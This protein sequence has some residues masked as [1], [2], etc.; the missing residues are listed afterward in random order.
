MKKVSLIKNYHLIL[1]D[2]D[3]SFVR[4]LSL[5]DGVTTIT[6]FTAVLLCDELYNYF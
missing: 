2:F 1:N 4:G 3:I 6:D 5:E